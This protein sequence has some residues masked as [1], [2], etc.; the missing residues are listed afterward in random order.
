[1][2]WSSFQTSVE[3]LAR[4]L[5]LA[6]IDVVVG[7]ARGG[8]IPAVALANLLGVEAFYSLRLKRNSSGAVWSERASVILEDRIDAD[9]AGQRILLVDDAVSEGLTLKEGIRYLS[10]EKGTG[11]I[12]AV[13]LIASS[14]A[15]HQP[16]FTAYAIDGWVVFPWEK[17]T[18][19]PD[20][21][22]VPL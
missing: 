5:K 15:I 4:N 9:L 16:D 8:L 2:D 22:A 3:G 6:E 10:K 11:E 12:T 18:S 19:R 13:S 17:P 7:I 1:M 21:S 14:R 20:V